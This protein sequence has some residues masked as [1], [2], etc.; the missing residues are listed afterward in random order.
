MKYK[1]LQEEVFLCQKKLYS[2]LSVKNEHFI[3]FSAAWLEFKTYETPCELFRA[4]I[5]ENI[6]LYTYFR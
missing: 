3:Y 6:V 2:T 5:L 1:F 4:A